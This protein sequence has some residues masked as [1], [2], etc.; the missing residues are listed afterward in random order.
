MLEEV[1]QVLLEHL[2]HETRVVLVLEALE[3]PDK[4][5]LV[6]IL[7]T[8]PGQNRHL[9]L[10]LARVRRMVLQD[11]DGHYLARALLPALDH[12]T[13]GS[14][15]QELQHLLKRTKKNRERLLSVLVSY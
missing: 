8:E 12:L 5:E 2:K 14:A 6:R 11:L 13:E 4:V 10:S 15:S 1:V 9:D 7:L 3:R